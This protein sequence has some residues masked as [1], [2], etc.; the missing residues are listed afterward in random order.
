[1]SLNSSVSLFKS[2]ASRSVS[3]AS[4]PFV[5]LASSSFSSNLSASI[6]STI[7]PNIWT[8]RRYESQ[9][10]RSLPVCSASPWTDLSFSPRFRT[11]SIALLDQAVGKRSLGQVRQARFGGDGEPRRHG[12]P[13]IGHLR[14]VCPLPPEEALHVPVAFVEVV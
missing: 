3:L 5:A 9:A 14:E 12:Q 1:M 6:P 11:V 13:D 4:S 8:N 7:F 10:K 2:P